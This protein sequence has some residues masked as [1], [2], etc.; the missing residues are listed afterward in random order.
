MTGNTYSPSKYTSIK[1][2]NLCVELCYI[3]KIPTNSNL[4]AGIVDG[5]VRPSQSA[6]LL[7]IFLISLD[8][9]EIWR[10][11]W[12]PI[13]FIFQ[14]IHL[15]LS[16]MPSRIRDRRWMDDRLHLPLSIYLRNDRISP[17]HDGWMNG[18]MEDR[19]MCTE[20]CWKNTGKPSLVLLLYSTTF[21]L[22]SDEEK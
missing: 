12:K 22:L 15:S 9:S 14:H 8:L 17:M 20:H 7:A 2:S 3:N 11:C 21:W 1:Q 19:W 18:W 13:V 10:Q 4:W 6:L 5:E 16:G